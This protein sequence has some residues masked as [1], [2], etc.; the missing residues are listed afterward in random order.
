MKINL[1]SQT[2]K[3]GLISNARANWNFLINSQ[4]GPKIFSTIYDKS[5][6]K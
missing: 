2:E 5:K 3:A 6:I 1:S 4:I